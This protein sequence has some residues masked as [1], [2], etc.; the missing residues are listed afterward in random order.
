MWEYF[1][2]IKDFMIYVIDIKLLGD[3]S[4]LHGFKDHEKSF[5]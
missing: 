5:K 1:V 2:K 4:I 3:M